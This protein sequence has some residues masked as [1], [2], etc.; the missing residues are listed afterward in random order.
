M[1]DAQ[2]KFARCQA[3]ES[4][5]RLNGADDHKFAEADSLNGYQWDDTMLASRTLDRKPALT[6]NMVR[7]KNLQVINDARQNKPGIEIRAIG[8]GATYEAAKVFEGICRHIEYIS[9]AQAAY[10]TATDHQVKSGIGYWR[11]L[12]QYVTDTPTA[13]AFD[14]EI[15]IRRVPDPNSVYLDPEIQQY[16]GSDARFGF[17][18]RD[19]NRKDY[20]KAHPD[21]KDD[22]SSTMLD[23][24]NGWVTDD[25][26]REAEFYRRVDK[27]EWL[28]VRA[29]GSVAREKDLPADELATLKAGKAQRRRVVKPVIEWFRI[30][31]RAILDRKIWPGSYIP[32][33]RVVGEE[34][35]IDG[36]LDRKGHTRA[37][38]DAQQMYNFMASAA[39]EHIALQTKTPWL[40]PLETVEGNEGIWEAAN[41]TNHAYLPYKHR[42]D[43]G[44]ELPRP[45]RVEPPSAPQAYLQ[46][47]QM[48]DQQMMKVTGQFEANLGAPSNET[49]GVA[50]QQRQRKG[51]NATYH[52][53]DHLGQAIRFTGRILIDLIPSIYDTA[54]TVQILGQDGSQKSVQLDPEAPDAHK[55]TQNEEDPDYDP[56]SIAAI[57]NPNVGR[58]E[59]EADIGP[60]FATKRQDE[61]NALS[62]L[63]SQNQEAMKI[64]ADLL[65]RAADFPGADTLAERFRR[66]IDPHLLGSDGP[67]PAVVAMQQQFQQHM[68]E[69]A[70][71]GQQMQAKIAELQAALSD[72]EQKGR[73]RA[74]ELD[75]AE[76]RAQ[77]DRLANVFKADPA[78]AQIFY[79]QMAETLHGQSL[80]PILAHHASVQQA[81]QP[82]EQM[83]PE[84]AQEG[85][86]PTPTPAAPGATDSPGL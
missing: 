38:R 12:T 62:Q 35:V 76:Y 61:F 70:Q 79:R 32:L 54:R 33:V 6:I 85:Q 84:G 3:W 64:G 53:I 49:S 14:Q 46:A 55:Q 68:T 47:M 36:K 52:Y 50:I 37:Q 11:V 8:D 75:T 16:D 17:V 7:E 31:G 57:F 44:Q 80:V 5:A 39:A 65:F 21:L 67:P 23:G 19:W 60:S 2:E 69:T 34:T 26:V 86:M 45:E 59:V 82:P 10:D 22:L 41:T 13:S 66:S 4:Q 25:M 18:F 73:D 71:Q 48:A 74:Q 30:M 29:D 28:T 43:D 15:Y 81:L 40:V 42:D 56:K 1:T 63:M 77:T 9:N 20:E 72:S 27:T 78:L 58:Y 83:P 24:P 51:D